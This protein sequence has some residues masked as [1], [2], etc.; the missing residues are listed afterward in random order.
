[1]A[2]RTAAYTAALIALALII[3]C[4]TTV[5]INEFIAIT[6]LKGEVNG[7]L[8]KYKTPELQYNSLL[9]NYT[10]LID[11]IYGKFIEVN[12]YF[13][14]TTGPETSSHYT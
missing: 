8:T 7:L 12:P 10:S 11:S 6:P 4:L 2:P 3:I 1:M 13:T 5:I 14:P 9:I